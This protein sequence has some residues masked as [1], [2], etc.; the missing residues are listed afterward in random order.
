MCFFTQQTKSA[1][2]VE[3]RFKATI[4]HPEMFETSN[5]INGFSHPKT[6]VITNQNIEII[7][8]F[9]W[10]LIPFWSH[11]SS[12]QK[13]TLNARIETIHEKPSF[14]N[15]V[16]NRCLVIANGFFEWQWLDEKGKKKQPFLI[17][18]P[19]HELFAFAGIWS[20]WLNKNTGEL[21]NSYSII[22]TEANDFMAE[23]HNSK[24]RMPVI[25]DKKNEFEWLHL[26]PIENFKS[27]SLK[28]V[29]Q[30]L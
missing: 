20:E 3:N 14:K 12:F 6:P 25:L 1:Q 18:R 21:I 19:N 7:Q 9:Q 4:Q 27:L 17:T 5:K 24:K 16:N 29:A 13:N 11:D 23:I 28:L 15:A 22:T 8:H 10:G 2:E 30:T 26:A